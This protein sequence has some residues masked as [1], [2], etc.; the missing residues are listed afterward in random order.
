MVLDLD[1]ML[2][3]ACSR[4]DQVLAD[5]LPPAV[6][7]GP[8][9]P[10]LLA[11]SLG[12]SKPRGELADEAVVLGRRA[13]DHVVV[14]CGLNA[15]AVTQ[16]ALGDLEGS[17]GTR[18]ESLAALETADH[19]WG[20][21]L[22]QVFA[23]DRHR[24]CRLDSV[25]LAETVLDA[26][27]ST[28]DLHLVGM[29]L[30]QVARLALREGDSTPPFEVRQ[31]RSPCKNASGT[32]RA[33]LP[34]FTSEV[35]RVSPPTLEGARVHHERALRLALAIGHAAAMCEAIEGLAWRRRQGIQHGEKPQHCSRWPTRIG[36][37]E[38]RLDVTTMPNGSSACTSSSVT[39]PP[40]RQR[41]TQSPEDAVHQ[42]LGE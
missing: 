6:L 16:W 21:A 3:E 36:T 31:R 28:G 2:A 5:N 35:K 12:N 13:D 38:R 24:S 11:A 33:S 17:T 14:G 34:H 15:L 32:P 10:P 22:C 23:L 30:E 18:E 40:P 4:Y 8:V 20:I 39:W 41:M 26:A 9:A 42:V 19:Q 37:G 7:Q 27:R 29:G 1:G 25:A